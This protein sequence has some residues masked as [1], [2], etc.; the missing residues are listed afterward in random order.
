ME[1]FFVT[2]MNPHDDA[3][4]RRFVPHARLDAEM[5][6][7]N[8]MFMPH[9]IPTWHAEPLKDI[10]RAGGKVGMG[11]TGSCR[12]SARTGSSWAMAS[13]GLTPLEAIRAAT[14]TAAEAMGMADDIGTL[15]VGKLADLIVL[16]RSPLEDLKNTNSIRYV[17]KAGTL[18]NADTMDEV[19]P[20][21][22]VRP[23]GLWERT[24]IRSARIATTG[25]GG[26]V[27]T[28]IFWSL[29]ALE[30]GAFV[31]LLIWIFSKG[32]RGWG[33]EGPVGAWLIAIPPILLLILAGI[34]LIRK[35]DGAKLMGIV[36]MGL[37]LLQ[38]AVGPVWSAI[39]RHRLDRSLAGDE[40]FTRPG[41]T[42]PGSRHPGA[43][44]RP[45]E[46]SDSGRRRPQPRIQQRDAT[47]VCA[48]QRGQLQRLPLGRSGVAGCRCRPQR[49]ARVEQRTVDPGHP[50]PGADWHAAQ[51]PRR[52]Q[53]HGSG[54]PPAV[55]GR[56]LR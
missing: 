24:A 11:S 23:R 35:S 48:G 33:P 21:K 14:A 32:S 38:I 41:S 12:D 7:H 2:T 54:R 47:A 30:A 31:I 56:A 15:E 55:V 17:M 51:G 4:L 1:S 52:S 5:H 53:S 39:Q 42:Q 27:I 37:P 29:F 6:A 26:L 43:R 44:C 19:W 40:S 36:L 25:R 46:E 10:V 22:R 20:T 8:R 28:R 50:R 49:R 3:K 13:A 18:W 45:R 34:V 16:D 9:E